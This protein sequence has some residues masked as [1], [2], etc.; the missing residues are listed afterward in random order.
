M[1]KVRR[2][3]A[4]QQFPSKTA[5]KTGEREKIMVQNELK[6]PHLVQKCLLFC[7]KNL[8]LAEELATLLNWPH[9]PKKKRRGQGLTE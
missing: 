4:N 1:K 9:V 3:W 7:S 2:P 6:L 5:Q 8:K